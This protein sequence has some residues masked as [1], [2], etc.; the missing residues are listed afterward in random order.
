MSIDIQWLYDGLLNPEI[1]YVTFER[2]EDGWTMR[3]F[4]RIPNDPWPFTNGYRDSDEHPKDENAKRLS[5]EAVP[6]RVR[7][8]SP[9]PS[10]TQRNQSNG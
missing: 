9:N 1:K 5:G 10:P 6:A 7:R 8:T 2:V 4:T 3:C